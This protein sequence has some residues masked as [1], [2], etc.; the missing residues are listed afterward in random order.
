[1]ADARVS[2]LGQVRIYLG[3]CFRIFSNEKGWKVLVFT[4]VISLI[5]SSVLSDE[6]FLMFKE[7][8]SGAF[9]IVCAAIWIGIFNSIQSICRER[10]IIKREYKTGLHI[11]SYIFAHMIY[12][13]VIC[14]AEAAIMLLSLSL[15]NE[16][17]PEHGAVLGGGGMEL[18]ITF[19]LVIYCADILG[20][21]VSSIV[22]SEKAAMTV[23]PFILIVQ[24]V[25]CGMF[26]PLKG[27]AKGISSLTISKWGME[28]IGSTADMNL[29]PDPDTLM[30]YKYEKE[31]KGEVDLYELVKD[32]EYQ[33]EF[34][35]SVEHVSGVWLILIGY[36]V[37]YGVVSVV[38]LK[39]I[40]KDKR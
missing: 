18:Y 35:A 27:I 29:M 28:A 33:P 17:V 14:L 38:A 10:D 13:L 31:Y 24:L 23:M 12:E 25:L 16:N 1:M 34:E 3:K 32:Q 8:K 37:L 20:M 9:T 5:I 4:A 36:T 39:S 40:E 30:R 7:T 26:F 2:R 21:A 15:F 19:F 11:S 6:T 22:K